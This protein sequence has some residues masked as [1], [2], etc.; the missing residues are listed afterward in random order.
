VW[1]GPERRHGDEVLA[2]LRRQPV[3]THQEEVLVKLVLNSQRGADDVRV[4]VDRIG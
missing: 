3:E 2:F 1:P 4:A